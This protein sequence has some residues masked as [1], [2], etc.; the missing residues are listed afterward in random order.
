[1]STVDVQV[2]RDV[3]YAEVDGHRLTLDLHRPTTAEGVPVVLYLHGGG[4]RAG[5]K[6]DDAARLTGLASQ[7]VAVASANY[8]LAPEATYPSQIHDAKAAVRWL[9]AHSSEHGLVTT[10][11]GAWGASA[12]GY[13][14]SMLGLT[15]G[16]PDL[17]GDVGHHT[18]Q[19]SAVQAVVTWFAPSDLVANSRRSWLEKLVLN[20]P[21][22]L[23]LFGRDAI[24]DDDA[25]VRSASPCAW[26]T[27]GSPPFLIAMGDR[28]RIVP[29][30]QGRGLHDALARQGV[31][32]STTLIGGAGHEDPRFDMPWH[33]A[34]TAAWLRH[35]LTSD[36]SPTG[37]AALRRPTP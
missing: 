35:Q 14:A 9:R 36:A 16:D 13:L 34:A 6:A 32:V 2:T 1:M 21:A 10:S 24:A 30:N 23:G 28:D 19:S 26:V 22:E 15:A 5:D 18:E 27:P 3:T 33:L 37:P 29:E 20:E 12:G 11:V 4:Y 8:R 31:D 17:E 7:G 25:L